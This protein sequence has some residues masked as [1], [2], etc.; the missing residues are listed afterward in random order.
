[1]FVPKKWKNRDPCLF[2]SVSSANIV[3][4][5][6]STGV[7]LKSEKSLNLGLIINDLPDKG[8]IPFLEIALTAS[9]P[10]I[11]GNKKHFPK[12]KCKGCQITSPREYLDSLK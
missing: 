5:F 11:T 12:G 1:V 7:A 8:D 4:K 9:V 2:S 3:K 6:Q 10:L